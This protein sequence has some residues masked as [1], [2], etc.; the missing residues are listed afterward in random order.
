MHTSAIAMA[1]AEPAPCP[2]SCYTVKRLAGHRWAL[3]SPHGDKLNVLPSR[4]RAVTVGRLLAG[5]RGR[6]VVAKGA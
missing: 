5:W 2:F 6:V 1:S 3:Y 4:Q